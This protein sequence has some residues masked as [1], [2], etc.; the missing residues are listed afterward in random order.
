MANQMYLPSNTTPFTVEAVE[1][2]AV[3]VYTFM[4]VI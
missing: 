1:S 4:L 2:P 3:T